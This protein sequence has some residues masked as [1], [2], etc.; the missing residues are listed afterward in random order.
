M[1]VSTTFTP[2]AQPTAGNL[3]YVPL[4]GDGFS[5]PLAAYAVQDFQDIGDATGGGRR[6]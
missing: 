4:G 3:T 5:A 1:A 2:P 6:R